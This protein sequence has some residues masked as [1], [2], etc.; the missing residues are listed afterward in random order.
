MTKKCNFRQSKFTLAE[1]GIQLVSSELFQ[2]QSQMLLMFFFGLGVNQNV[3]DK[4]HNKLIQ[5]FHKHRIHE[6]HEIGWGIRKSEGHHDILIE[7]IPGTK[8]CFLNI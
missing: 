4:Y 2:Y 3:V 1:F 7:S 6:I 8:S 5:V